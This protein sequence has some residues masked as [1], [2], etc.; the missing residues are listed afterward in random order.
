MAV[1]RAPE[2]GV[3]HDLDAIPPNW[4]ARQVWVHRWG[5]ELM[6]GP[7]NHAQNWRTIFNAGPAER[8]LVRARHHWSEMSVEQRRKLWDRDEADGRQEGRRPPW[9]GTEQCAR[10]EAPVAFCDQTCPTVVR[11]QRDYDLTSDHQWRKNR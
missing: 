8:H 4:L 5:R 6:G 7:E 3:D 9:P 2:V 1:R 10:C 11:I